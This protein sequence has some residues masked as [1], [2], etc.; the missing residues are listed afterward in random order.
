MLNVRL[1]TPLS[2]AAALVTFGP[3][4]AQEFVPHRAVY[5]V[6][7]LDRGKPGGSTSGTYAYELR[8]TCDGYV[9]NQRLRLEMGGGRGAVTSEQQ[10]QLTES[11][12]GRRL[13]F[14]HR[15]TTGG[16]QANMVKG[17]ALMG[18]DGKGEARFADPEGQTVALPANTLFPV[19]IARETIRQAKA[20]ETGFDTQFFFGEKVKPPQSVNILIGRL[21]K[22]LADVKIPEGAEQLADGRSRIYYRAGFFDVQADGKGQGEPAYEMSS[23]TLDNGIELYGTH[24]ENDGSIEYRITRLE[25]LPKPE[26]K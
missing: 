5:A 16:K 15:T 25:A 10:S 9:V 12:D 13:R 21:P 6:S 11:R 19:A 23:V 8:L 18:D 17:E 22:R 2:L 20:G 1:L 14:E 4:M 24:E 7:S 3:A 26:C